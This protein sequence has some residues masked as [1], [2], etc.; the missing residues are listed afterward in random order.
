[1]PPFSK[2]LDFIHLIYFKAIF[3]WILFILAAKIVDIF[4]DKV[5]LRFTKRTRIEIDD[6]IITLLHKPVYRSIVI[7]GTIHAI[8]YLALSKTFSFYINGFLKSL[9]VIIW[10]IIFVKITNVLFE[11]A[12]RKTVDVTNIGREILPLFQNTSRVIIVGIAVV[13][14]LSIW[15]INITPLLASAGIA[16]IAVALAAKDTIA[17]FFGGISIFV[18]RPYK[19]GDY[20]ILEGSERGEVVDIGIRSTRLKT[21]DDVLVSIP[22]SIIANTTIVNESAPI[23]RFRVRVGV[24]VAYGSD[25]DRVEEILLKIAHENELVTEDPSPRVR[26]RKFGDSSL[27]FELLC[28]VDDPAFKGRVVHELNKAIYN[29]FNEQGIKIPFPQ[30]DVYVHPSP[31]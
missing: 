28:W 16:G 30:R 18:D 23:P 5:L 14:F 24:G 9:L 22:N 10:T 13:I 1:M 7:V 3:I 11:K 4:I 17:N 2:P 26:F 8:S 15:K 19:L 31:S 6:Q 12:R 29:I 27:D 25:I 21:R 20:I